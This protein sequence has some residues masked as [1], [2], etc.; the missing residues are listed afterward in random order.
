[1]SNTTNAIKRDDTKNNN[2]AI[3]MTDFSSTSDTNLSLLKNSIIE[4]EVDLSTDDE[5]EDMY[6]QEIQKVCNKIDEYKEKRIE[7]D[8]D[9]MQYWKEKNYT[10]PYLTKLAKIVHTV[11][12]TQV[13]VERSFS[14]LKLM[15][16]ERRYN[17]SA[18]NLQK[19]MFIKLNDN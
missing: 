3:D 12:V 7:M 9:L 16:N 10:V 4:M 1:M 8:T 18:E 11:P 6:S 19:L 17:L 2:A 14:A 5:S 15:L 13:S